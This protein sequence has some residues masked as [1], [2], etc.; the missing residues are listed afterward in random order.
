[1]NLIVK[2][3]AVLLGTVAIGLAVTAFVTHDMLQDKARAETLQNAR[4]MM[5]AAQATRA[6][7]SNRVKGLLEWQMR[8]VFL[9]ESVPSF[10][11]T[12]VFNALR[13]GHG[14]FSYKEAALNPTNPR[15]RTTDWEADVV[16]RF[17]T[18]GTTTELVGERDTPT[19]KYLY[20]ARPIKVAS[21]SCLQC[22][23]TAAAAPKPMI[24]KYGTAGGFGWALNE[25]VGAQIVSVPGRVHTEHAQAAFRTFMLAIGAVFAAVFV[26]LNLMLTA[27]VIRPVTRLAK[28]AEQASL[29]NE[30]E[31]AFDVSGRDEIASLA[32]AFAR[33]RT[34]LKKAMTLI[35]A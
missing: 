24:D 6:Y 7:T 3:N 11:A 25:T 15:D 1:M 8:Y 14:E 5:D 4:V 33:M 28:Q 17:R 9:P 30:E 23:S 10:A 32:R 2:F 35:E 34:S 12:E 13:S 26:V 29:G 19:G 21:E 27:F 31:P 16:N 20:L 22:H 18:D